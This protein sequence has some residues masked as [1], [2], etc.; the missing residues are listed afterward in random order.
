MGVIKTWVAGVA[1]ATSLVAVSPASALVIVKDLTGGTGTGDTFTPAFTLGTIPAEFLNETKAACGTKG[2]CT[3]DFVFKLAGLAPGDT[4]TL[5]LAAQAQIGKPAHAVAEKI[6]FDVFKG[7]P[8]AN[9]LL[10]SNPNFLG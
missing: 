8:G 7:T 2:G 9:A 5:Q 4:T 6:S 10:P 1:L 3:Y